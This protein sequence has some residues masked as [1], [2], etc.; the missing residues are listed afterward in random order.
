MRF[1]CFLLL[2]GL[3]LIVGATAG[4]G[5]SQG[6]PGG[7]QAPGQ[8]RR[9]ARRAAASPP[10]PADRPND[11]AAADAEAKAEFREMDANG[12]GLLS[13]DEMD[14][15]LRAERT[16]WDTNHDGFIDLDEF[17][18]YFKARSQRYRAEAQQA[19]AA[20]TAT[21]AALSA[22]NQSS[23]LPEGFRQYDTDH[24]G[25]IG[26]YEWKAAGQPIAK[27]LELDLNGDG[28]LTRDELVPPKPPADD[29]APS[30]GGGEPDPGSLVGYQG[31][32]GKVFKFRVTG[33]AG[34]GIWGTGVY[35]ADSR[36][37]TAAV[38]AGA[39]KAGQTGT[40]RVR[41]VAP[42]PAFEGSTANGVTSGGF[43]QFPGAYRVLK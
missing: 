24:D 14:D 7:E 17:R 13:P 38:H 19:S 15:A 39:L 43:G 32:I 21:S 31:Q 10:S 33:E 3:G 26:L 42:P 35:T 37:A 5:Q 25:Q 12:D 34:G 6:Q 29:D 8:Q 41:I 28:F 40:V 9:G 16:K 27:F 30:E 1:K 23:D 18:A 20:R 36:L 2:I 11:Q 22:I 4:L